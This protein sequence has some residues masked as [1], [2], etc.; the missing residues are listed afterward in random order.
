M[1]ALQSILGFLKAPLAESQDSGGPL[2]NSKTLKNNLEAITSALQ[3]LKP[4]QKELDLQVLAERFGIYANQKWFWN[5]RL[6]Y[7]ENPNLNPGEC[8][9]WRVINWIIKGIFNAL[10]MTGIGNFI[11][12]F[13]ERNERL[14]DVIKYTVTTLFD[15]RIHD[16]DN[17]CQLCIHDWKQ[18]MDQAFLELAVAPDEAERPSISPL[19]RNAWANARNQITQCRQETKKFWK[20]FIHPRASNPSLHLIQPFLSANSTLLDQKLYKQLDDAYHLIRL[21]GILEEKIPMAALAQLSQPNPQLTSPNLS[22]LN[23]WISAINRHQPNLSLKQLEKSM[24]EVARLISSTGKASINEV[25]LIVLLGA[26]GCRLVEEKDVE[27]V[28]WRE[29]LKPGDPIECNGKCL[30]L[31][32]L[33]GDCKEQDN[34]KVFNVE[35]H[36]EWVIRIGDNRFKLQLDAFKALKPYWHHGI[37]LAKTIKNIGT[38][39]GKINGLDQQGRCAVV[40]KLGPALNTH[41]WS[42][43]DPE[44]GY[45]VEQDQALLLRLAS[46]IYCMSQWD[47]MPEGI[48]PQHLMLDSKQVLKTTHLLKQGAFDYNQFEQFC[49]DIA[50]RHPPITAC[51]VYISQLNKHPV[52]IYYRNA[53]SFALKTGQTRLI[54]STPLLD[55][56]KDFYHQQAELLSQQALQLRQ[57]CYDQIKQEEVYERLSY[58]YL[59]S[60][61]PGRLSP[62][63]K[64]Q[65]IESF[66]KE[67]FDVAT[68]NRKQAILQNYCDALTEEMRLLNKTMQNYSE[69]V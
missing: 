51:L 35:D 52:A 8:F 54:G 10:S 21:E 26:Y 17:L 46:L 29:A 34:Y 25:D 64:D 30:I 20:L 37:P 9:R 15:Q 55:E 36:P 2:V 48:S 41:I 61:T 19:S 53:I 49:E 16:I 22:K 43:I 67:E 58:F 50:Q 31:G 40:Q 66:S 42:N 47:R 6:V 38:D 65:V 11:P 3:A 44:E 59:A 4:G 32:E 1:H 24:R 68:L 45:L 33:L 14:I 27:Y 69:E 62:S 5:H 39:E 23:K 12:E 13:Y 7:Q 18:Q 57:E 60:P 28:K 56:K 63:L